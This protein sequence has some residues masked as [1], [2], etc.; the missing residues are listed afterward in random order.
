MYNISIVAMDEDD[1][2]LDDYI[3]EINIM[4]QFSGV[5][6]SEPARYYTGV[7]SLMEIS[8]CLQVSL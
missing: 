3:D 8:P 4:T 5:V 7:H 2:T 1:P 6:L